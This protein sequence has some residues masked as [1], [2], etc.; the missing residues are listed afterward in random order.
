M[1]ADTHIHRQLI[2]QG[3]SMQIC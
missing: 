1:S 2:R 3:S